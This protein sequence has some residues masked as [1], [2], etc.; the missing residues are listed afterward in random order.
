MS[1]GWHRF[2]HG[3][4]P[5]IGDRIIMVRYAANSEAVKVWDGMRVAVVLD[6]PP[7]A[8]GAIEHGPLLGEELPGRPE[9]QGPFTL[10]RKLS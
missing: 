9:G 2:D 10:W 3:E 8:F 7:G 6:N 1:D 5:E 4:L